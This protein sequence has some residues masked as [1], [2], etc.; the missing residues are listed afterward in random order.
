MPERTPA[1]IRMSVEETRK[2]LEYSINDL[3]AKVHEITNWRRQLVVHKREV[4][5]GAALAG[6]VVGGGIA[7]AFGIFRR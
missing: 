7:A 6:F 1:E 2:E 5:I 4:I 3:Q